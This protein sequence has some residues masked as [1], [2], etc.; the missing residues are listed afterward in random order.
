LKAKEF[1]QAHLLDLLLVGAIVLSSGGVILYQTLKK[2]ES[3]LTAKVYREKTLLEEVDLSSLIEEVDKT[4]EGSKTPFTVGF[5]KGAVAIL[6]SGCPSQYCVHQGWISE[7][8]RTLICA[9]NSVLV[10]LSGN[11]QDDLRV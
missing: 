5:K 4:Y 3:A 8:G 6:E 9:Y 11:A 1:F 10:S 2:K 7:S